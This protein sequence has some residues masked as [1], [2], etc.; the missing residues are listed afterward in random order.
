MAWT[1]K[2]GFKYPETWEEWEKTIEG[3]IHK[4]YGL[5][6]ILDMTTTEYG[7]TRGVEIQ[8]RWEIPEKVVISVATTGAFISKRQNPSLPTT[9]DEI[10]DSAEECLKAGASSIHFHIRD[11]KGLPTAD[12]GYYHAIIDPLKAKYP[13]LVVDAATTQGRTIRE[14]LL[15]IEQGLAEITPVNVT[16]AYC[17]DTLRASSPHWMMA[18]TEYIQ[19]HNCKP[20]LGVWTTGDIDNANRY[21]IKTG[22]LEKPYFW[23][24]LP[25]LP[26]GFPMP[27]PKAMMQG[28]VFFMERIKE[29]D[30]DSII[31]V[32]SSVRAS[33]YLM[34]AGILLGAQAIRIGMEDSVYQYPHRDDRITSNVEEF[35][36]AKQIAELLGRKSATGDDFRRLIGLK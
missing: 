23:E 5:P 24:V 30:P 6:E 32:C 16:A 12:I 20:Q 8:P 34:T 7:P 25:N 22:I 31:M 13:D 28:L 19:R 29:I 21:L 18:A 14:S 10:R 9:V 26:G 3:P 2:C 36:R 4:R 11:E 17:G 33:C 15:P 27:N 1:D 35:I